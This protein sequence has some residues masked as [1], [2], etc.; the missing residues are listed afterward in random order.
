MNHIIPVSIQSEDGEQCMNIKRKKVTT[1]FPVWR[2][3]TGVLGA[4]ASGIELILFHQSIS[5]S[6]LI[7]LEPIH[8]L[9]IIHVRE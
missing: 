3:I 4:L 5:A 1:V 2:I 7:G 8:K 9:A 6:L